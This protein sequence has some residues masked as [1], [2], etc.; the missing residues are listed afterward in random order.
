MKRLAW[1][2]NPTGDFEKD[3]NLQI[4]LKIWNPIKEEW[5]EDYVSVFTE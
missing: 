4:A 2:E 3:D 5:Q 1:L